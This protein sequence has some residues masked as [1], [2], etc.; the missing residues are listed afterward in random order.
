ML[1]P[2][3]P[4]FVEKILTDALGRQYKVVF[5]I[6]YTPEG[7]ARGRIVS[8]QPVL[9]LSGNAITN[10]ASAS[11]NLCLPCT[12]SD[13]GILTPYLSLFISTVSPYFST[14]YL[15]TSQPTRAPSKR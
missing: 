15:I 5:A 2:Y 1:A 4:Q 14:E 8:V 13:K 10:N 6:S 7:S 3:R 11:A 9:S 12:L